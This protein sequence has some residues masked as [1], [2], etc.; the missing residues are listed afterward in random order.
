MHASRSAFDWLIVLVN[1]AATVLGLAIGWLW[2]VEGA[3]RYASDDNPSSLRVGMCVGFL[4]AYL[5]WNSVVTCFLVFK[6]RALASKLEIEAPG[7]VAPTNPTVI[8]PPA[9]V[10]ATKSS[11]P[12]A[13]VR[14][15][16]SPS[17]NPL[18]AWVGDL[19]QER[20]DVP[21]LANNQSPPAASWIPDVASEEQARRGHKE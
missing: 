1:V 12:A 3:G 6:I 15:A 5:A 8:P 21:D 4:M 17:A 14:A 13:P 16:V 9:A 18:P 7:S 10:E 20:S 19:A 11:S 2:I